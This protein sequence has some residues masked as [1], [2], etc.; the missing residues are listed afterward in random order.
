MLHYFD[1]RISLMQKVVLRSRLVFAVV[2]SLLAALLIGVAPGLSNASSHREAPLISNDPQA[3]TTDVYAFV[4]PELSNTVTLIANY[5]PLEAPYGGPNFYRFADDV[6]Y[7]IKVDNVGDAQ[8]HISYQ[9]KFHTAVGDATTFLYNTCS[10]PSYASSCLNVKQS[11]TVT[12]VMSDSVAITTTVLAG[13]LPVPPTNIGSASTP[14]YDALGDAGVCTIAINGAGN[15]T[16]HTC[17]TRNV[18][19]GPNDIKVFAGPRDDPF[20]VDLGSIFD[21]LHLRGQAVPV[22]YPAGPGNIPLDG[23]AGYN[24]H[25]IALQIPTARLTKPGDPVIGVW[26]TASRRSTR[27]LLGIGGVVAGNGVM[28]ETGPYVQVSRLGMPLMNEAVLPLALKDAFNSLDPSTD[29]SLYG[30]AAPVV[31]NLLYNSVLTPELQT[32]LGAL[33]GVPNPG[34]PRNDI[35]QIFLQGMQ[36]AEPFTI[37]TPGGPVM[38]PAN[39]KVN[40]PAGSPQPAEMLRLNTSFMP[41][42]F[43]KPTPDYLLGLLGGDACGFPNGRRLAD[44]VTDIE[45]LAVGGAA[46][47]PLTADHSFTMTA[48]LVSVLRD[49]INQNDVPFGTTFPYMASPHSGQYPGYAQVRSTML[50]LIRR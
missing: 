34:K 35:Q 37:T 2:A 40:R 46:W 6:L 31:G 41:A 3:D 4:S 38:L 33:Y 45:L 47:Q 5:I 30:P 43:C 36:L 19:Q 27:V 13:N 29:L 22:G 16:G 15:P 7:E 25:S 26:S 44:D 18:T 21:L 42:G 8:T 39:F 50:P 9:F 48:G 10:I 11:Y 20:F 24:V 1:E 12:E 49:N 23:L 32:L 28:T 14:N 17:D